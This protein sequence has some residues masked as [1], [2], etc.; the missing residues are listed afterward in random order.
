MLQYVIQY[1]GYMK[2]KKQKLIDHVVEINESLNNDVKDLKALLED[3][4]LSLRKLNLEYQW[5]CQERA[6]K[7]EV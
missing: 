3:L 2:N 1:G 5:M 4:S 6:K 7:G